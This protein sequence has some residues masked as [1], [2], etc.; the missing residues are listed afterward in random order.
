MLIGARP[1][2]SLT[3]LFFERS[4]LKP[5]EYALS[6]LSLNA[7]DFRGDVRLREGQRPRRNRRLAAVY[8]GR[9]LFFFEFERETGR[10]FVRI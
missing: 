8:P 1:F 9:S 10:R 6:G 2:L 7:L 4:D 5:R 3:L